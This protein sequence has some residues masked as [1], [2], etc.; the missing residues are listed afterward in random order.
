MSNKVKS[1][2][3]L[4]LDIE[5]SPL[6]SYT[7]G[8]FDQNVGLNQ[9]KKDWHVLS[10]AAKWLGDSPKKIIYHD[11]S[12]MKDVSDDK[13]LMEKVWK[14]IDEADILLTQN[15]V[16]FDV[17]KLNARFLV[18]GLPPPSP[19]RHIDT[20]K[21][22]RKNFALTSN[23]LEYAT[24][25]LNTKYKK[26]QH[27]KFAG[28]SLWAE[29][30]KGNKEAWKE[31]KKYNCYDILSLEELYHKL[32]VWD[33]SINFSAYN[34]NEKHTCSCGHTEFESRGFSYSATGKYQRL[35]CKKCGKWGRSRV[36]LL[37]KEK[38]NGIQA[39]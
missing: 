1:P 35:K 7:W 10:F 24:N 9:I 39:V 12:Q 32:R 23:K 20:L 26:L 18:H 8:L 33:N 4:L 28:F 15:G 16:S 13:K 27:S 14:L 25:L 2:K 38:R 6:I 5:T 17:K 34:D 36:N 19:V 30:L 31:M 3:I 37:T 22:M 29:C 21:I 11:Q